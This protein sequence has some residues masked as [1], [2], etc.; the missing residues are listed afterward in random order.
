MHG[1]VLARVLLLHPLLLP[2][3]LLLNLLSLLLLQFLCVTP[4]EDVEFELVVRHILR[5]DLFPKTLV[6]MAS[7][8]MHVC[9]GALID[10]LL[11][12]LGD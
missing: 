4:V 5:R 2:L 9:I 1:D 8:N 11:R 12:F 6:K 7:F 3:K 10:D